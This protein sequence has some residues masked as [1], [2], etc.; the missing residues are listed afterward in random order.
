MP[1][2]LAR[3]RPVR[4]GLLATAVAL[5]I[6]VVTISPAAAAPVDIQ[7]GVEEFTAAYPTAGI[8]VALVVD[9]EISVASDGT[10]SDGAPITEHT[11]FRIASLSKSFTAAAVMLA[12]EDGL[13]DLDAP[14]ATYLPL[15]MADPRSDDV[16]VR[17]LLSH[18]SGITADV[19]S[20]PQLPPPSSAS[21]IAAALAD[22]TLAS[23]PG[24]RSVY[25]NANYALA[26][27]VVEAATSTTFVDFLRRE[28]LDPLGMSET[29]SLTYCNDPAPGLGIGHATLPWGTIAMAD[30]PCYFVGSGGVV[31]T[32]ADLVRWLDFQM[33]GGLTAGG[34]RL[35][36]D[37]SIEQMRTIQQ[38]ADDVGLGWYLA[39]SDGPDGGAIVY[40]RGNLTTW[41]GAMAYG[42]APN[43]SPTGVAAVVLS[44]SPSD[45][46]ELAT[47]LVD[48]AQGA[49]PAVAF[50]YPM[51]WVHTGFLVAAAAV[52]A[53]GVLGVARAGRWSR[54]NGTAR[55]RS[56][57]LAWL[58]V[59]S[60]LG[61]AF[62][63]VTIRLIFGPYS[64]LL[65]AIYLPTMFPTGG[66]FT[67]LLILAPLGVLAA[68]LLAPRRLEPAAPSRTEVVG[69]HR[70]RG[71]R[72]STAIP[73]L[74]G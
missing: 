30:P 23:T 22:R 15:D 58:V 53:L 54:R 14:V 71:V 43:G 59:T 18:T 17:M 38:G 9:G 28:L 45:P 44:N 57:R 20:D 34:Q 41:S 61:V 56:T 48:E 31:S 12:V 37:A 39:S 5:A 4:R 7:D 26:A 46:V 42:L 25:S 8:A 13:I 1:L 11:P 62:L 51:M 16:T 73:E 6:G 55:S 69:E 27:G 70:G 74:G 19:Y 64:D 66:L 29:V 24:T 52:L 50:S 33:S 68:R 47:L 10:D 32:T 36:S 72:T 49:T 2:P 63:P 65:Y 21:D 67:A 60:L 3:S 40:H 35:L